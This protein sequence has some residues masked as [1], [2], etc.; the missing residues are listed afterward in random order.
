MIKV[1]YTEWVTKSA[2]TIL[3][4]MAV[5]GAYI[6]LLTPFLKLYSLQAFAF[7]LLA[8]FVVKFLQKKQPWKILP[9]YLSIEI[10]LASF[11]FLLLIGAT[12][13]TRSLFFSLSYVHL[14]FLTFTTDKQTAIIGTLAI[15]L[16]HFALSQVFDTEHV[17]QLLTL[18]L[19]TLFFLFAKAQYDE[20]V[21]DQVTI[22]SQREMI[23]ELS[24]EEQTAASS[25]ENEIIPKLATVA[26]SESLSPVSAETLKAVETQL[27]EVSKI[28]EDESTPT[29]VTQT[30]ED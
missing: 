29:P 7:S 9:G 24:S 4:L 1:C 16:F 13:N 15:T 2:Q 21:R 19:M 6:W 23:S 25:I 8:Y 3:I 14:F 26:N 20:L 12:G 17:V 18:P 28:L 5:L 10:L 27:L 22:S 11:A 30:T